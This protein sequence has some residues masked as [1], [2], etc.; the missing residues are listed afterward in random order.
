MEEG[1]ECLCALCGKSAQMLC[2]SD[3][4]KLCWDCDRTVHGANFLVAKHVR[5]LLCRHCHRPTPWKASGPSLTVTSSLCHPCS[6]SSS[7]PITTAIHDHESEDDESE[8]DE[9]EEEEEEEEDEYEAEE[10]EGENQVVPLSSASGGGG[11]NTN[12][13]D[14]GDMSSNTASSFRF[15]NLKRFQHNNHHNIHHSSIS[16]EDDD[17]VGCCSSE[18]LGGDNDDEDYMRPFKHRRIFNHRD[19]IHCHNHRR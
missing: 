14:D 3:Q 13:Y 9:D 1:N 17:D 7:L 18:R 5:V 16:D 8:D 11:G 4:A 15:N 2:E 6:S 12:G 10:E 19:D